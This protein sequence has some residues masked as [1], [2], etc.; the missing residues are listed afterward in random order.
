L[1][2]VDW[3]DLRNWQADSVASLT[4]CW[5]SSCLDRSIALFCLK[6]VLVA[7]TMAV[8][9]CPG[10]STWRE[11]LAGTIISLEQNPAPVQFS[12]KLLEI[13]RLAAEALRLSGLGVIG[14]ISRKA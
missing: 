9:S 3:V 14:N 7:E 1:S 12:E 4:R 11:K 6:A 10:S 2:I 8:R 5:S 13:C